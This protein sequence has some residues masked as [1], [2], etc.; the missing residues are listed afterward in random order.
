MNAKVTLRARGESLED[1]I[2]YLCLS[3]MVAS[4][5]IVAQDSANVALVWLGWKQDMINWG[6]L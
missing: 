1:N 2:I 6:S 3:E 5:Q 4:H